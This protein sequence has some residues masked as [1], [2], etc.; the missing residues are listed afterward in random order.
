MQW[1]GASRSLQG[2]LDKKGGIAAPVVAEVVLDAG[3]VRISS[4]ELWKLIHP[5]L[6]FTWV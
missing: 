3:D 6:D 4:E 1:E 2:D 5:C